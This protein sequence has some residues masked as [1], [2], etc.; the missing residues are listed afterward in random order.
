MIVS[1]DFIG[2]NA[3]GFFFARSKPTNCHPYVILWFHE[4]NGSRTIQ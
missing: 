3:A 1:V 4:F 2:M